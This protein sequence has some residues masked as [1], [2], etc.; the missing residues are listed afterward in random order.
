MFTVRATN[1]VLFSSYKKNCN[2]TYSDTNLASW[3]YMIGLR[4]FLWL[5]TKSFRQRTQKYHELGI[6]NAWKILDGPNSVCRIWQLWTNTVFR[7]RVCPFNS[8][9]VLKGEQS[10]FHHTTAVDEESPKLTSYFSFSFK[11][12]GDLV[13]C[14]STRDNNCLQ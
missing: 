4:K 7:V 8:A 10:S 3:F 2:D 13:L 9:E 14:V 11:F 6:N 1:K 5:K 12:C